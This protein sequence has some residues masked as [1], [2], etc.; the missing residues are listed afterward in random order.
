MKKQ[1]QNKKENKNQ[2]LTILKNS[3]ARALADYDNL[4]KRVERDKQENQTRLKVQIISQLLPSF[5]MLENAQNH[6]N[7][8]GLAFALKELNESLKGLGVEKI[9]AKPGDDFNE[10]LHEATDTAEGGKKGKIAQVELDGW[11]LTN[12][13]IIRF[14]KVKV[15]S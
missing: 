10:K 7:D 1:K 3:L 13:P 6:L 14:T 4:A 9:P 8:Q 15:Y 2:E 12:G 5:D 11:R